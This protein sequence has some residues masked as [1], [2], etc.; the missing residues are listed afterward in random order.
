VADDGQILYAVVE[1]LER[2][3]FQLLQAMRYDATPAFD[4][5]PE[6]TIAVDVEAVREKMAATKNLGV[7]DQVVKRESDGRVIRRHDRSGA[8]ADNRVDRYM[9]ANKLAEHA[10]MGGSAESARA[11]H[12]RHAA[13]VF[14]G[15]VSHWLHHDVAFH[16]RLAYRFNRFGERAL[17]GGTVELGLLGFRTESQ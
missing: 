5:T 11:E 13:S 2:R 12:E 7:V 8:R 6:S 14:L 9:L 4:G 1:A 17:S 15:V 10:D 16:D 3:R